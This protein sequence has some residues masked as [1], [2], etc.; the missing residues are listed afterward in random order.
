VDPDLVARI[1]PAAAVAV[2]LAAPRGARTGT[3]MQAMPEERREVGFPHWP[4]YPTIYEINTWVWLAGLGEGLR[5]PVTL[6]SVPAAEWDALAALGFD[7]V[8]LMGVWERSPAGIVIANRNEGLREA[9]RRA[10][11]DFETS[12]NVGSPYC[13][14]RYVVDE[15]LGGPE[16]LAIARAEL[17]KRGMRLLLDFVP[18][19]VAP[20]HPWVAEHPE[21]LI[22]G[23][24]DHA[25][26]DP[27]SFVETEGR[28]FACGRDPYFPAWPDVVQLNAFQPG[29]RRAVVETLSDIAGQCDGVRCDMA[30]LLLNAVFE[31]TWAGRA[32]PPPATDYWR[33]VIPAVK[34]A[35]A[36]FL[37]V[38]E[39]Y[40]E[41]EWEL[42]QQGFDF[43]YDKRLYDRLEKGTAGEVRLHLCAEL[44]YQAKLLRFIENHD[45][46]RARTAFGPREQAAAVTMATLP[47]ARLLH[48]GQFEGRTIRL[49]VFLGRRPEE[50][51]DRQRQSFYERL[52]RAI[53]API[54]REGRWALCGCSGWPDN[55]GDRDVLA[56]S[57]DADDG[58]RRL[59]VV[60]FSDRRAQARVRVPWDDLRGREWRLGDVLSGESYD[61]GGDD[62]VDSGLY[63]DLLPWG[64]HFF[65]LRPDERTLPPSP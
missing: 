2:G 17:A 28:F 9:F 41:L 21:Y 24:A 22:Q 15:H 52:L 47:G 40:W 39:A 56:W 23:S 35:H 4:R 30:M 5:S 58:D 63:V 46:P 51:A 44:P 62:M 19:H 49:S 31:R 8:W 48:E 3:R 59:I 60:N 64:C 38:A 34:R 18:N 57:W 53:D 25:R 1:G 10:L 6:A 29:L 42:Q 16:G 20:D 7:A 43:C 14:R 26:S 13:V 12:D 65:D 50:P 61:R 33:D 37:F 45:E 32:G 55:P 11:P 54:F 36:A 27:A